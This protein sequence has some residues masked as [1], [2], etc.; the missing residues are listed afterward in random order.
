MNRHAYKSFIVPLM[1][2][3]LVVPFTGSALDAQAHTGSDLLSNDK[4]LYA[5]IQLRQS[6]KFRSDIDYILTVHAAPDAVR[7]ERLGAVFTPAEAREV[8]VRLDLERDGTVIQDFFAAD[9]QFQE[10]FGGIHVDHAAGGKLILQLVAS[11]QRTDDIPLLLPHLQHADRLHINLVDWPLRHLNLLFETLS[12]D[13]DQYPMLRQIELD[14]V[15]NQIVVTVAPNAVSTSASGEVLKNTL[16]A[17]LRAVLA[18][19]AIRIVTGEIVD[20]PTAIL[21]GYGWNTTGTTNGCTLGFEV[22]DDGKPSMLTAGHCVSSVS[23]GTKIYNHSTHI[24][25]SS[26]VFQDGKTT[27]DGIAID[28]GILA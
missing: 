12:N 8:Q 27:N 5:E 6:L 1:L 16:P 7:M 9:P 11:H 2:L 22:I 23:A 4:R 26:G 13:M 21:A 20:I 15:N 17:D 19:P 3:L 25:T 10:A 18:D 24:G 14:D 28:V